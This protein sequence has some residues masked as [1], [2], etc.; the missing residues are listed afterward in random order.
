MECRVTD[1]TDSIV[2]LYKSLVLTDTDSAVVDGGVS[3][4]ECLWR[5][6][7]GGASEEERLGR[8]VWGG[9][10][11][12]VG[13]GGG[14]FESKVTIYILYTEWGYHRPKQEVGLGFVEA[15]CV[16]PGGTTRPMGMFMF[17][18]HSSWNI[19]AWVYLM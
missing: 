8:S 2:G 4:E 13:G 10:G 5:S 11:G 7:W 18:L 6:D 12:A 9:V 15:E 16:L 14:L 3:V 1:D 19:T 17:C